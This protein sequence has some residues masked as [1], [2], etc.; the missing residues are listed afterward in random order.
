M[1]KHKLKPKKSNLR[2]NDNLIIVIY[3]ET[4]F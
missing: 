2:Q 4:T 1:I 3:C